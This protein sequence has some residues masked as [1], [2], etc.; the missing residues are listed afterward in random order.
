MEFTTWAACTV[1]VSFVANNRDFDPGAS[2]ILFRQRPWSLPV[3][4]D[5]ASYRHSSSVL[6]FTTSLLSVQYSSFD[7]K[8]SVEMAY[9]CK[10]E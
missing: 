6:C 8:L 4:F 7:L 10:Y 2:P 1:F 3:N 5:K 9:P